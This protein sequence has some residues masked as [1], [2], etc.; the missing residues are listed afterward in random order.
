MIYFKLSVI[1]CLICKSL[2]ENFNFIS[3]PQMLLFKY[4]FFDDSTAMSGVLLVSGK[5]LYE[6]KILFLR[7]NCN[8]RHI[9]KALL[10]QIQ[11]VCLLMML[12]L[13]FF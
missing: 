4:F 2:L 1:N 5:L 7:Y 3:I 10:I 13:I 12:T 6:C 11:V 9:F 8:F